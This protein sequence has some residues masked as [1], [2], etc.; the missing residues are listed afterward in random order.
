MKYVCIRTLRA[1]FGALVLAALSAC[2]SLEK[3]QIRE[4][5]PVAVA[6]AAKPNLP[7]PPAW[8][9]SLA[10]GGN[11]TDLVQW[12]AQ[13]SDPVLTALVQRAQEVNPQVEQAVARIAGARAALQIAGASGQ[14]SLDGRASFT[15]AKGPGPVS[16]ATLGAVD[17][18]WEL[19]LF[20]GARAQRLAAAQRIQA[21]QADWHDARVS[22]AAEVALLYLNL[23]ACERQ[24]E[25]LQSDNQ[26]TAQTLALTELRIKAGFQAPADA[27]LI[28]ATRAQAQDRMLGAQTECDV[29]VK[30]LSAVTASDEIALRTQLTTSRARL[31]AL[32]PFSVVSIPADALLQRADLVSIGNELAA[33]FAEL[34]VAKAGQYPR[35]SLT[36]SIGLFSV[37]SFG[38]TSDGPSWSFGPSVYLPLFNRNRTQGQISAAQARMDE[39]LGAYKLKVAL[40]VRDTEEALVRLHASAERAP[41]AKEAVNQFENYLAAAQSRYKAGL[42][43]LLELEEARRSVLASSLNVLNVERDRAVA[44]VNLYKAVGGGFNATQLLAQE[45]Q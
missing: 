9:A 35:V 14:P 32:A 41:A 22:L 10:H 37:R 2:A 12:W 30:S 11:T 15:R 27:S 3:W 17:A 38:A 19:D 28:K 4:A 7:L 34:G 45:K 23:R 31:P 18:N 42:G 1:A 36:G 6:N 5:D 26:S 29:L 43:S 16:T 21:R 40:A 25:V 39:L 20:G 33:S 13:A 44:W 24:V 8:V